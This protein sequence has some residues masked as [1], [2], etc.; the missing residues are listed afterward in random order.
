MEKNVVNLEKLTGEQREVA[1]LVGIE[2]Y[3]KLVDNFG[4]SC[5][6]ISKSDTIFQRERDDEIKR[7]FNGGN[8]RELAKKYNLSEN[9]IR[10][11]LRPKKLF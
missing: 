6:Y 3:R 1:E 11:I 2:N 4:G 8:Y 7:D 9:R 10:A 5:V